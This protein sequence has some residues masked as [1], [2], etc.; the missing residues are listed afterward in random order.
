MPKRPTNDDN[1]NIQ[2]E[3][4]PTGQTELD[5]NLAE[6]T[7][8]HYRIQSSIVGKLYKQVDKHAASELTVAEAKQ[9]ADTIRNLSIWASNFHE[10]L[11]IV[12][13]NEAEKIIALGG[14]M[15]YEDLTQ[16]QKDQ[17]L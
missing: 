4:V 12:Q 11:T 17:W 7:R 8:K 5:F 1:K 16:E 6:I 10:K 15:S 14:A 13:Q 9:V 3:L 2:L